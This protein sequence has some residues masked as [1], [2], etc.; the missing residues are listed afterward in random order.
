MESS[1]SKTVPLVIYKDGIRKVIGEATVEDD[2]HDLVVTATVVP[3]FVDLFEVPKSTTTVTERHANDFGVPK[4]TPESISAWL[5]SVERY[6]NLDEE[7][8]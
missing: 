7:S 8:T 3:T 1:M 2:G 6:T 4:A 5:G